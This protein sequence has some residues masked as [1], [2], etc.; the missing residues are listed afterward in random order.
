MRTRAAVRKPN[1]GN[2]G[3][4]IWFWR[5]RKRAEIG[6]DVG[7]YRS[8]CRRDTYNENA[9]STD[10]FVATSR[11]RHGSTILGR[12]EARSLIGRMTRILTK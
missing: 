3:Y 2:S 11:Y 8:I 4:N 7:L 1:V 9:P 10:F 12:F 6:I 5:T